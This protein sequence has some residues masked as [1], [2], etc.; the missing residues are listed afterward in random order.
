AGGRLQR[1][2]LPHDAVPRYGGRRTD[3]RAPETGNV[4]SRSRTR[5]RPAASHRQLL[6]RP[7]RV[8]W[9][10]RGETSSAAIHR[11][12][13]LLVQPR[14]K[15]AICTECGG[16]CPGGQGNADLLGFAL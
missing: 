2:P 1:P 7:P 11:R 16:F 14:G 3:G 10:A 9:H 12:A 5:F 4:P 8:V 15:T 6:C 13:V